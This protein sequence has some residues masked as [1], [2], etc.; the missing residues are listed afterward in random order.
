MF[1]LIFAEVIK[2]EFFSK[3][4]NEIEFFKEVSFIRH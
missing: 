3:L 4:A 1:Y 2:H